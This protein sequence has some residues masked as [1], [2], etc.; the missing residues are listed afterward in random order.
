M[1]LYW[2]SIFPDGILSSVYGV[3]KTVL[4]NEQGEED[5]LD[6]AIIMK[7]LDTWL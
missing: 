4:E 5:K 3:E 1:S 6:K 7:L 2:F